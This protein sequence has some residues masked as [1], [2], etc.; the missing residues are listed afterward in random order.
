MTSAR[1]QSIMSLYLSYFGMTHFD[2]GGIGGRWEQDP[3][4]H[5]W[6]YLMRKYWFHR[7]ES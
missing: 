2:C 1:N 4:I 3:G 7:V 6:M 5:L